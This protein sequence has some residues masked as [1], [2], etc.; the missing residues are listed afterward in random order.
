MTMDAMVD[1]TELAKDDKSDHGNYDEGDVEMVASSSLEQS[2]ATERG[3]VMHRS[4][5]IHSSGEN[6]VSQKIFAVSTRWERQHLGGDESVPPMPP[7][8]C[9]PLNKIC[10]ACAKPL[11]G[12]FVLWERKTDGQPY[13][14]VGPLWGFCACVTVPLILFIAGVFYYYILMNDFLPFWIQIP[15]ACL[16]ACTL[17]FL[18]FTSCRNPGLIE[19]VADEEAGRGGWYWNEQCGTYRPPSAMYCRECKVR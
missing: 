18:F 14:I 8:K 4:R 10:C 17:L 3:G 13:I 11:G 19:R 9:S 1:N 7:P 2:A 12:M 6:S 15:Y 16:V 5:S